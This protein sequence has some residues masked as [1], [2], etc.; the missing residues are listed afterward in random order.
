VSDVADADKFDIEG[1]ADYLAKAL[2]VERKID[3]K[4]EQLKDMKWVIYRKQES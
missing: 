3:A 2:M 4:I 1:E